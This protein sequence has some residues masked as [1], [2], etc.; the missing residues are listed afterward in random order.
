WR[1]RAGFVE[2]VAH[3][4]VLCGVEVIE[5]H[6]RS[7]PTGGD[8]DRRRFHLVEFVAESEGQTAHSRL[9]EVEEEILPVVARVELCGAVGDLDM[10]TARVPCEQ[11]QCSM[12]GVQ[13]SEQ[14]RPE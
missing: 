8:G 12:C 4:V 13:V 10:E 1:F 14:T 6:L 11:G 2:R 9:R 5:H 3:P 7:Q